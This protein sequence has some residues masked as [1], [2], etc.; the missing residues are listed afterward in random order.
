MA[1]FRASMPKGMRPSAQAI[2][3]KL[4]PVNNSAP[5]TATRMSPRENASPPSTR[6]SAKP[7]DASLA[8]SVKYSAP[9]L[10]KAP[11]STPSIAIVRS[12]SAALTMP[13]FSIFSAISFGE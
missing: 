11:A 9:K 1:Q 2:T 7:S 12:G 6:V 3:R 13:M 10:M 4:L 8:T 5:A